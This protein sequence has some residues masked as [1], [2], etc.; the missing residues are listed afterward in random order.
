MMTQF[1]TA[2]EW[3]NRNKKFDSVQPEVKE[4]VTAL[5]D[6][7]IHYF[8]KKV[9]EE[10][11]EVIAET[12]AT[13]Q[14]QIDAIEDAVIN[15]LRKHSSVVELRATVE[16]CI[17]DIANTQPSLPLPGGTINT[18]TSKLPYH[19]SDQ[20]RDLISTNI[21]QIREYFGRREISFATI[22]D[23]LQLYTV[24]RAGD[25]QNIQTGMRWRQQVSNAISSKIWKECPIVSTGIRGRYIVKPAE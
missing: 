5:F 8:H 25:N 9:A 21:T 11:R 4:L 18:T 7:A 14:Q 23:H 1:V 15:T 19:S 17:R 20:I 24:M 2:Q 6:H 12:L 10:T 3:I 22:C 16:N 13:P